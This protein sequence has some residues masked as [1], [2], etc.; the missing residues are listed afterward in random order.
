M[1]SRS[2]AVYGYSPDK[3]AFVPLK[4]DTEGKLYIVG[5][6]GATG[7]I[8]GTVDISSIAGTSVSPRDWSSDFAQLQNLDVKLSTVATENTLSSI[9]SK[10]ATES[11]LST[12][13]SELTA[14]SIY[15]KLGS[16]ATEG[17]LSNISS[18]VDTNLS[19]R[20]SEL[21]AGSIYIK[22]SDLATESTLSSI[23]SKVDANLSTRAS[24][25]TV[26]SI[27]VKTVQIEQNTRGIARPTKIDIHQILVGST[28][29]ALPTP[30]LGTLVLATIKSDD[31]NAYSIFLGTL[32]VTPD[33]GF[34][35]ISSQAITI[36][37][38]DVSDLALISDS[39]SQTPDQKVYILYEGL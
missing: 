1:V 36:D 29:V 24:E 18:R 28:A 32:Q 10:V 31:S 5:G 15:I 37:V 9:D 6:I 4:L 38:D 26:G 13:A 16:L 2:V 39:P 17:T 22:M 11:T 27:Y 33:T 19:T 3:K 12:R 14:G 23:D 8:Q 7:F 25:L 20:A 30:N 21:T 34:R 35:L